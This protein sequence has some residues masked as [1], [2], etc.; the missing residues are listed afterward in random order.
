MYLKHFDHRPEK[1]SSQTNF[2]FAD[3]I[4][5]SNSGKVCSRA[6]DFVRSDNILTDNILLLIATYIVYSIN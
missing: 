6:S 2:R 5:N 3:F 1:L 4:Q